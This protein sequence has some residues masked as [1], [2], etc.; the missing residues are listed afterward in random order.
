MKEF[1]VEHERNIFLKWLRSVEVENYREA[2]LKR[3]QKRLR[4]K[5]D[6]KSM[7]SM[8]VIEF[9]LNKVEFSA[10]TN[11]PLAECAY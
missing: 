10:T 1:A 6:D 7:T 4:A 5:A 9:N 3:T 11:P 8:E 2:S